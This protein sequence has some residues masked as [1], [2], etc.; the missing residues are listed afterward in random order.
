M[1]PEHLG[2]HAPARPRVSPGL[3]PPSSPLPAV[4][5]TDEDEGDLAL[6][7]AHHNCKIGAP[8]GDD[9]LVLALAQ[10]NSRVRHREQ[11]PRANK[12]EQ[13]DEDEVAKALAEHNHR[14]RQRVA[15]PQLQA[16]LP[17][18]DGQDTDEARALDQ[19]SGRV[20]H[21]P[22]SPPSGKL[23]DRMTGNDTAPAPAVA[24]VNQ[25]DEDE[26]VAMLAAHNTRVGIQRLARIT[27]APA[28]ARVYCD[29]EEEGPPPP[30][31]TAA[32]P[33]KPLAHV[34]HTARSH[35]PVALA[36]S[37]GQ[38]QS[39][40]DAQLA[41]KVNRHAIK[42]QLQHRPSKH[43]IWRG[44]DAHESAARL[45]GKAA[46]PRRPVLQDKSNRGAV[47]GMKQRDKAKQV[48]LGPRLFMCAR[49]DR[50]TGICMSPF[51]G[52]CMGM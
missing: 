48:W 28:S 26:L 46:A 39:T 27:P 3:E 22:S 13:Q 12:Q 4:D 37:R 21:Q 38:L 31:V 34:T 40:L 11:T 51:A 52:H 29:A 9:E 43:A 20:R 18:V 35:K 7:L 41:L 5:S 16:A 30:A 2:H 36:T 50:C 25:R 24:C 1:H 8:Q 19:H 47:T 17:P 32:R 10:H 6:L 23:P 49:V 42:N 15:S 44:S 45:Q 14:V 33:L